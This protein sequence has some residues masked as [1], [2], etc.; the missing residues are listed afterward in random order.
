MVCRKADAARRTM[1]LCQTCE[2]GC[3]VECHD[4]IVETPHMTQG[5][6]DYTHRSEWQCPRCAPGDYVPLSQMT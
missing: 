5:V 2:R 1:L 3:H 4:D 6:P